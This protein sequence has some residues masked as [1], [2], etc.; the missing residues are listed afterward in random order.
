MLATREVL[1]GQRL[2]C[3]DVIRSDDL[4]VALP[5]RA[6]L[7]KDARVRYGGRTLVVPVRDVGPWNVPND[8]DYW[9][10]GRR[11]A[12]ERGHGSYRKPTNEAGIDLSDATFAALGLR[13]NALVEWRFVHRG[14][15]PLPRLRIWRDVLR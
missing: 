5:H 11:P 7:H 8:D 14:Y 1:V 9:T 6:A 13:D 10:T 4:F 12:A 3:G 2:A 15:V